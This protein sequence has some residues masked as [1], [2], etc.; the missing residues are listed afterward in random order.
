MKIVLITFC[1]LSITLANQLS[2]EPLEFV[3]AEAFEGACGSD[4]VKEPKPSDKKTI[5]KSKHPKL[6]KTT[7]PKTVKDSKKSRTPKEEEKK[8]SPTKP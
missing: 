4:K 8:P 3:L 1:L 2:S 7:K 5:K 6:P